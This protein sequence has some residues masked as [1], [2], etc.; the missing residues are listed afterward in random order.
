MPAARLWSRPLVLLTLALAAGIGAPAV[1]GPLPP[2]WLLGLIPFLLLLLAVCCWRRWPLTGAAVLLFFCLGQGLYQQALS[3]PLHPADVRRLPSQTPLSL[4]GTVQSQPWF[5]ESGAS[6]D[7]AAQAWSTGHGWQPARGLVRVYGLPPSLAAAP[8]E[9]MVVRLRLQPVAAD[10]L[11]TAHRRR[12]T[13]ARQQIFVTG[14]AWPQFPPVVLASQPDSWGPTAWRQASRQAVDD[15][16]NSQPQ[17]ARGVFKALLLGDQREVS[18]ELR[19]A[20]QRTGTSHLLAISGLHL[21]MVAAA[22][23]LVIFWLLRRWTWLLLRL[24]AMK[25]ALVSAAVPMLF[26]AWVAGGSP[27]TQRAA[28]MLLAGLFLLLLDRPKDPLSLLALAALI[29]LAASPLQLYALSFQLSFLSVWGL[30]VAAPVLDQVWQ[31]KMA[32]LA[33]R[34]RWL[35]QAA[36]RL[37]QGLAATVAATLATLPVIVA[38][39]HQVPTYGILINLI[40][41]PLFGCIILPGSFLAVLLAWI[42]QPLAAVVLTGCRWVLTATLWLLARAASLPGVAVRLPTPTLGQL[43][44]Y[45]AIMSGLFLAKTRFWRWTVVLG[46]AAVIAATVA[47]S[48]LQGWWSDRFILTAVPGCRQTALVADFPGGA[49]MFISAGAPQQLSRPSE[50][51]RA[52]LDY[53]AGKQYRQLQYLAALTITPQNAAT[54]LA[55]GREFTVREFWYPGDRPPLPAFWELRNLLGDGQRVVK[56]LALRPLA[57]EI[58]GV[59]MESRQLSGPWS[60]RP[61]GPVVLQCSYRGIKVL[62]LPPGTA[63]WRRRVLTAGLPASTVLVVSGTDL[64]PDFLRGCLGQVQPQTL[65]ITGRPTPAGLAALLAGWPGTTLLASQGE[66]SI[67][68]GPDGFQ[69]GYR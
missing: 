63:E 44:A 60:E 12:L 17:P 16:L 11:P 61:S 50:V 32:R 55:L 33:D 48:G 13:L 34:P 31:G 41:V 46:G 23:Y 42:Y 54:L 21:A 6:V 68:I 20:L 40:M 65:V 64:Q 37:G 26:Y 9:T 29:I 56:N 24:N 51:E 66:V 47:W 57:V 58:A 67:A 10:T 52:V 35:Q 22:A 59:R 18:P 45:L 53:L 30:I 2:T 43:G 36:R 49:A 38:A 3:P 39:F 27:A 28:L 19:L 25:A 15:F 14:Q 7:L 1:L 69:V 4:M 5:R 8:G 62:V